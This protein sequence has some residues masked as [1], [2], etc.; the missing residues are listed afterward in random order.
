[1]ANTWT[2]YGAEQLLKK[3]FTG[4]SAASAAKVVL[5]DSMPAEATIKA[6]EDYDATWQSTHEVATVGTAYVRGTGA[7]INLDDTAAGFDVTQPAGDAGSAA[8]RV[9]LQLKDIAFTTGAGET[10]TASGAALILTDGGTEKVYGVFDF[11]GGTSVTVSNGGALTLADC[12]IR[13]L[14]S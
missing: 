10:L 12:E 9:D 8:D 13:I 14:C 5:I 3:V 7:S 2:H 11:Q 1:M 4:A 6:F